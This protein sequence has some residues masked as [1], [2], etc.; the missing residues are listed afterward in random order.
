MYCLNGKGIEELVAIDQA[1]R[2]I[3]KD[4]RDKQDLISDPCSK[5]SYADFVFHFDCVISPVLDELKTHMENELFRMT[6]YYDEVTVDVDKAI[7][8]HMEH[9]G[10]PLS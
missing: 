9:G 7:Q 6:R 4:V 5:D 8:D 3:L 1:L 10:E 2:E